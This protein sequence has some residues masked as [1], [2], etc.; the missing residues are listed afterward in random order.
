MSDIFAVCVNMVTKLPA[1]VCKYRADDVPRS[2]RCLVR[3]GSSYRTGVADATAGIQRGSVMTCCRLAGCCSI[4]MCPDVVIS[5]TDKVCFKLLPRIVAFPGTDSRCHS[6][7]ASP[8]SSPRKLCQSSLRSRK[9]SIE[10]DVRYL[11]ISLRAPYRVAP[12]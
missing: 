8:L 1:G 9:R 3:R 4:G 5:K 2:S 10:V 6:W 7:L 12:S 11:T